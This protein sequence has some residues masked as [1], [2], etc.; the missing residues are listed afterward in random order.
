MENLNKKEVFFV[1]S[2]LVRKQRATQVPEYVYGIEEV[3]AFFIDC[4]GKKTVE[5]FYAI[6]MNSAY[7]TVALSEIAKGDSVN[8]TI[9]ISEV[10][11][12]ALLSNSKYILISHNHPSGRAEPSES[13]III[14]K[15]IA[16]AAKIFNVSL[17]DSIIVCGNGESCS[18]RQK[19]AEQSEEA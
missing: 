18:I 17:I 11:R 15:Q 3:K 6:Y 19:I 8:V 12:I 7:E 13:D 14:T 16:Q 9:S 1:E 2:E 5:V 10:I 4:I